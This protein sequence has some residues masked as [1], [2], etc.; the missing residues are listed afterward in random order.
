MHYL[1]ER[2]RDEE[3]ENTGNYSCVVRGNYIRHIYD[4]FIFNEDDS[5]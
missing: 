5:Q 3:K 1:A 4:I 2:T